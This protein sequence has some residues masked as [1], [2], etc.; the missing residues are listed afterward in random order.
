MG[1]KILQKCLKN[2]P[3][4]EQQMWTSPPIIL[5]AFSPI[6]CFSE[7]V[8]GKLNHPKLSANL[9]NGTNKNSDT[10]FWVQSKPR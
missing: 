3:Q 9:T 7:E 8:I 2:K 1:K 4:S 10:W 5:A 6:S